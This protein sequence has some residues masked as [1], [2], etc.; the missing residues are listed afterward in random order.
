M[1]L[2]VYITLI[3]VTGIYSSWE[4]A[5]ILAIVLSVIP[6]LL[7]PDEYIHFLQIPLIEDK[8][9]IVNNFTVLLLFNSFIIAYAFNAWIRTLFVLVFVLIVMHSTGLLQDIL[10]QTL[11]IEAIMNWIK[12]LV[13]NGL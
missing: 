13:Q 1:I 9:F 7:F 5:A 11:P 12:E 4:Y 3:I 10:G 8:L 6:L 2:A